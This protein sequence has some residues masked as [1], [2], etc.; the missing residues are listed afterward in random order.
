MMNKFTGLLLVTLTAATLGA[1]SADEGSSYYNRT[2]SVYDNNQEDDVYS[3][4]QKHKMM[5]EKE[6][7]KKRVRQ[8]RTERQFNNSVR[9]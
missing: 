8:N 5:M 1:C 2:G 6:A 3:A 9:K 7:P 4:A